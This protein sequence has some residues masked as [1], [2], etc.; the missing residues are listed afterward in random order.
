LDYELEADESDTQILM[1]C[2][3]EDFNKIREYLQERWCDYKEGLMTLTAVAITTNTAFDLFQRAEK[4]L[5]LQLASRSVVE[6]FEEVTK[7]F[8]SVDVFDRD[9]RILNPPDAL[10]YP[11]WN[12]EMYDK[13][14]WLCLPVYQQLKSLLAHFPPLKVAVLYTPNQDYKTPSS[15]GTTPEQM[16]NRNVTVLSQFIAEMCLHKGAKKQGMKVP[17]EDELQRGTIEMLESRK[18]PLWLVFACQIFL[19]V[20]YIL[21]ED[22][23]R[24]QQELTA[25]GE[26]VEEILDDFRER[27]SKNQ[28]DFIKDSI[29]KTYKEAHCWGVVDALG[30]DTRDD[31]HARA[32]PD[33]M[34]RILYG[35]PEPY[36]LLRRHPIFCGLLVFRFSFAM[37][38]L[39]VTLANH[40]GA[41]MAAAHI[42]NAVKS[43]I[44]D[45]LPWQDMETFIS[46]HQ[47]KHIFVG[48]RPREPKEYWR[49]FELATGASAATF[50]AI[51]THTRN[52]SFEATRSTKGMRQIKPRAI[53]SSYFY[54]RFCLDSGNSALTLASIEV[55]SHKIINN[56]ERTT[57]TGLGNALNQVIKDEYSKTSAL[58]NRQYQGSQVLSPLQILD[59]L[60]RTIY[61]ERSHLAFNYVGLH[62]RSTQVL[63]QMYEEFKEEVREISIRSKNPKTTM[64]EDEGDL[65][66][67]ARL[68]LGLV[69]NASDPRIRKTLIEKVAE[70]LTEALENQEDAIIESMQNMLSAGYPHGPNPPWSKEK[71]MQEQWEKRQGGNRP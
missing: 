9:W 24:A 25:L 3:F 71:W 13:A 29:D 70:A 54:D 62:Q 60:C 35:K 42:Y 5:N 36:F 48:E 52:G 32:R 21:E 66:M 14:D 44:P 20:R 61:A 28:P 40:W 63:K 39:G 58:A 15:Y 49:R 17:A 26:Q 55:L 4:E 8:F 67:I 53:A 16:M 30:L 31:F 41:T 57:D 12:A 33:L 18:L 37:Q 59:M 2:F 27:G 34:S 22:V 69:S 47:A 65:P 19:D 38:E 50:S 10:S 51:N 7:S 1:Y 46:I 6:G 43:E 64:N 68:T 23:D 45:R 56:N 11:G